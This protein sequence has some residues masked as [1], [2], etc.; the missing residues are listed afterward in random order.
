MP[1]DPVLAGRVTLA[2]VPAAG[3]GTADAAGGFEGAGVYGMEMPTP[4]EGE[5]VIEHCVALA[6]VKFTGNV[7][8][9][10]VGAVV[11]PVND[12]IAGFDGDDAGPT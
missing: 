12:E 4:V 6:V 2:V 3:H 8:P 9:E 10:G 11:G 1:V 5:E 7:P